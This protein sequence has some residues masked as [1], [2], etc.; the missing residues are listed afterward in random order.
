MYKDIVNGVSETVEIDGYPFYGENIRGNTSYNRRELNRQ[1]LL[2]G[3][4]NVT[5]G[6]YMPKE[7]TF[8]TEVYTEGNPTIFDEI[9][10]E[11]SNKECEVISPYMGG[12]FNAEI[13]I[14]RE[15]EEASPEHMNLEIT[16]KEIPGQQPN[17]PGESFTVPEDVLEA[18]N[19]KATETEKESNV[20]ETKVNE[21]QK[22]LESK[23]G[24]LGKNGFNSTKNKE[25]LIKEIQA[26]LKSRG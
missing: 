3:T 22:Q 5:R 2:G 23:F 12:K 17:I 4:E 14:D 7:Y 19:K 26:K 18:E 10:K 15:D 21:Q 6:K 13:I 11:M 1:K 9:F 25:Q 8:S 24:V 20:T 16:V